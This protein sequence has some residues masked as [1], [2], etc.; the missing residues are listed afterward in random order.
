MNNREGV[1]T[2]D[3]YVPYP[4]RRGQFGRKLILPPDHT[5]VNE[6]VGAILVPQG[7][8]AHRIRE[9]AQLAYQADTALISMSSHDADYREVAEYLKGMGEK[10]PPIWY[11]VN[12]PPGWQIPGFT[13]RAPELIP[14]QARKPDTYNLPPKRNAGLALGE[15]AG[16]ESLFFQDDDIKASLIA[17]QSL[18]RMLHG[19]RLA[20]LENEGFEDRD[21][22]QHAKRDIL[23]Y[24]VSGLWYSMLKG[25]KCGQGSGNSTVVNPQTI[26]GMF[27]DATYNEDLE[28]FLRNL[29]NDQAGLSSEYYIQA[30]HDPF[31]DP[32]RAVEE[33]WGDLITDGI[34]AL[35]GY[36]EN[37]EA[38]SKD[39]WEEV[40][41]ART[42]EYKWLIKSV[43]AR[44]N[45]QYMNRFAFPRSD[46]PGYRAFFDPMP[47]EQRT[48]MRNSLMAG[49]AIN[50][51]LSGGEIAA[52][53]PVLEEDQQ[54]WNSIR[55]D[56]PRGDIRDGLAHLSLDAYIT[57]AA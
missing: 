53:L 5:E 57:N 47:E 48:K 33:V 8:P 22:T 55:R 41:D 35:D 19:R 27:P 9:A 42:R 28:L 37:P 49:Q 25:P 29:K 14:P 38:Y 12:V 24:H 40:I 23:R 32:Q 15:I 46:D 54:Q 36:F 10:A 39:Y 4:E 20:S 56:F 21:I 13:P 17:L 44:R 31:R 16:L 7:R 1:F 34:H 11:A 51:S 6:H 30:K 52:Y 50:D 45:D 18:M 43:G 3:G 2:L 26:D